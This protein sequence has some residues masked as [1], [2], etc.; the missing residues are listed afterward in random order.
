MSDWSNELVLDKQ[1]IIVCTNKIIRRGSN[2]YIFHLHLLLL[3]RC[4]RDVWTGTF[5]ESFVVESTRVHSAMCGVS[6]TLRDSLVVV[7]LATGP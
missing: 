4:D 2:W 3:E 6:I 5:D 7:C 1:K